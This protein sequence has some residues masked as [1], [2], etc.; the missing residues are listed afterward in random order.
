MIVDARQIPDGAK[1]QCDVLVVGT[2]P[3]GI[4][5]ALQLAESGA[6][7]ILLEAGGARYSR[8]EQNHAE[9]RQVKVPR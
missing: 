2:G 1:L 7:V 9:E 5:L 6:D 4:P 3:A 8:D